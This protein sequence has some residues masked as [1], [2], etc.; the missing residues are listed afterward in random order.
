MNSSIY[1]I[2]ANADI[3]LLEASVTLSVT[4]SVDTLEDILL[5]LQNLLT[6]RDE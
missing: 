4:F 2:I 5:S 1:I 3:I 6:D